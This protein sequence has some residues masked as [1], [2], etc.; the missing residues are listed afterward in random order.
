MFCSQTYCIFVI[1]VWE[2][3]DHEHLSINRGSLESMSPVVKIS[4]LDYQGLTKTVYY[5][6]YM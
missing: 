5:P 3:R 2:P 4:V 1:L 6:L